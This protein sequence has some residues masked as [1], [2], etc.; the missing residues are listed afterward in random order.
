MKEL[1]CK[2]FLYNHELCEFVN[3]NMDL[4]KITIQQIVC[5]DKLYILFYW[6]EK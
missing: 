6:V 3:A 2:T 4:N 5:S 1:R